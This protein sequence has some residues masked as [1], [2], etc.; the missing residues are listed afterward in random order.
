METQNFPPYRV[1]KGCLQGAGLGMEELDWDGGAVWDEG[2]GL[3]MGGSSRVLRHLCR[4]YQS[5]VPLLS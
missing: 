1:Q 5:G 3:G 4:P 2:A